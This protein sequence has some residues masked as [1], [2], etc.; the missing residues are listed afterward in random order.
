[1]SRLDKTALSLL[2]ALALALLALVLAGNPLGL[3]ASLENP[4]QV[5]PYGPLVLAFSRPVQPEAVERGLAFFPALEGRLE[6][7]ELLWR[8]AFPGTGF[9]AAAATGRTGR[10][11]TSQAD[12]LAGTLLLRVYAGLEG[13]TMEIEMERDR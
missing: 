4:A 13:G 1:M 12:L 8:H 6:S 10:R 2:G 11:P 3:Q 9:P 7:E 5:G